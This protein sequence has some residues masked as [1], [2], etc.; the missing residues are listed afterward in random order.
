MAGK[1]CPICHRPT[2][3]C[4]GNNYECSKCDCKISLPVNNG[5]GGKGKKCPICGRYTWFNDKC[6]YPKCG[7]Y[8]TNS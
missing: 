2:L 5:M 1:M 7:A 6:H 4:V 8:I 3:F